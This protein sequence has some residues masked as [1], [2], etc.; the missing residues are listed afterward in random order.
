[1]TGG[2]SWRRLAL[3]S[4]SAEA[5]EFDDDHSECNVSNPAA[6]ASQSV[7]S[8]TYRR[9]RP[10]N[11]RVIRIGA[12]AAWPLGARAAGREGGAHRDL[13]FSLCY[14]AGLRP[15]DAG[16]ARVFVVYL[17][18][19]R[20]GRSGTGRRCGRSRQHR[21]LPIRLRGCAHERKDE[22]QAAGR[23]SQSLTAWMRGP[24]CGIGLWTLRLRQRWI[25][26]RMS[27]CCCG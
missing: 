1:M 12:A 13:G 17:I 16:P 9:S 7:V 6:P 2:G 8:S 18:E 25:R 21:G 11:E 23:R 5:L 15:A 19:P 4:L 26:L 27:R 20:D 14:R 22:T 3:L 24:R 10:L